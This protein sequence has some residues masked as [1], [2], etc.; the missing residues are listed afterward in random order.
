MNNK[1]I[2]LNMILIIIPSPPEINPTA[3]SI[4]FDENAETIAKAIIFVINRSNDSKR[5]S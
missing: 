5:I 1:Q 2:E 3:M 4:T